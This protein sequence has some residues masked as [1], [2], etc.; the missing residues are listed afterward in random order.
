VD[1]R[2]W[3]A[4]IVVAILLWSRPVFAVKPGALVSNEP[5]IEYARRI[6]ARIWQRYGY[7]LTL[8]SGLD[9][10]H[11]A[12]SKHPLGLAEDYRTRDVTPSDLSDMIDDTRATL[13]RD[14]DIVLESDHLHVEYDPK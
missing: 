10:T 1:K 4:I 2:I 12:Q 3:I 14:Y 8:T 5:A 13:G 7:T 6:L 9:S 11:S